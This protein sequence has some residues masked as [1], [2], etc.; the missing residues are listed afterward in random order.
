MVDEIPGDFFAVQH[1]GVIHDEI[2]KIG[3]IELVEGL[4]GERAG[5]GAAQNVGIIFRVV[6]V[7]IGDLRHTG[8]VGLVVGKPL[9]QRIPEGPEGVRDIVERHDQT[10]QQ[11]HRQAEETDPFF[12]FQGSTT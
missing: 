7:Q 11:R 8:I 10:H 2:I 4:R 1:V 5:G 12:C 6:G 9:K 3:V